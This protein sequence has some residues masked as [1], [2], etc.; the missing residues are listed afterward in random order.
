MYELCPDHKTWDWVDA[1]SVSHKFAPFGRSNNCLEPLQ[2][3]SA[4]TAV[5]IVLVCSNLLCSVLD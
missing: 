2:L 4:K 3:S 1:I 5:V